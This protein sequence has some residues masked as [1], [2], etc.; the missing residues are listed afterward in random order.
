[1]LIINA[2]IANRFKIMKISFSV[3][4]VILILFSSCQ[5]SNKNEIISLV[6]EW[7]G[8]EILFP[9]GSVFTILE[10]DTVE[11]AKN[12]VDYKIVTYVD[13]TGCMSCKLQ[14]S[15][16]KEFILELDTIS[17]KKIPFL[18][19]FYPK[20]K[21]ELNFIVYRNTFNYPICIDEKDSFNKLNHFPANMMFQTFLLD[22]DNR[23]LAI[24]NPIHSSKVKELYLK[25]IQ[26][27]KVQPNNKK[28][29]I[30]TEVS[31]DKTT[32]FLDHFDWHKEQHAKF[33]L[34]NTGKELLMIYDVTTSC[35]CTEV[36]YSK[37]PTRPG[38]S[39]SL[40]V[41]YKAEHPERFD[42]SITVYCNAT[43]SPLQLRVKGEAE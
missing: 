6:K 11:H 34:T 17:P 7:E 9:T 40:N 37:E 28:N 27:D 32:M 19:Y 25:I 20:N 26:G 36:A 29:I 31:V 15:R 4:M 33:I 24:G 38:A 41:T 43:S 18:F 14:L 16:W 1:M 12:D 10:R 5:N 30:Q 23:V 39:V 2:E 21:S 3:Y 22:R 13:S 35:G 42:K 8:K